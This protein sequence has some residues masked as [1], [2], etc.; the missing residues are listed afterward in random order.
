MGKLRANKIKNIIVI[1]LSCIVST[2]FFVGCNNMSNIKNT[3]LNNIYIDNLNICL[4]Y[5]SIIYF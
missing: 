1:V 5:T 3:E 2:I 4:L